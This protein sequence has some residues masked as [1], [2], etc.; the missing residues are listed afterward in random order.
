MTRDLSRRT[1]GKVLGATASALTVPTV[2]SG[3]ALAFEDG[4]RVESTVDLN[5]RHHPGTDS[6]VVATM[7]PGS[8]GEIMNGPVEKGGY[9]WWGVHWLGDDI[10]GWSVERY[11]QLTDGGN[12]D[13]PPVEW[14]PVHSSN[15]TAASRGAADIRWVVIH[16]TQGSFEGTVS[17]LKNPNSNVSADYVIRNSDGYT[18]QMVSL[19]DIAWHAGGTNYNSH[20]IGIEH[21]GWVGETQFTDALYE[22]SAAIVRGLCNRFNIPKTY[23]P[24]QKPWDA[25]D[26]AGIMGHI[27]V[28]DNSHTDPGATWDWDHFMNLVKNS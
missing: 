23:E 1:F 12:G 13:I 27:Q 11:L 21:E 15:Y 10:W 18:K 24:G 8:E 25:R 3:T 20:S 14:D 5:T 9:T 22:Q 16:V 6:R 19:E 4:D 26:G 7:P 17:W 28:P 2:L